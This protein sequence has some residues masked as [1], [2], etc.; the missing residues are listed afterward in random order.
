[1]GTLTRRKGYPV[2]LRALAMLGD[3]DWRLTVV[4]SA[5]WDPGHAREIEELIGKAGLSSRVTVIG[6]QDE[7][8]LAAFYDQ[9]DLF[10]L[11]SHHEG[12]GMVLAEALARGLPIV[13]TTA[14]A[15]PDTV[16]AAAGRLVPPGDA[17]ALAAALRAVLT[18]QDLYQDLKRGAAG[19]RRCLLD[20]TAATR[21]FALEIEG[22]SQP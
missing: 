10:V 9:A 5:S 17:D 18:D 8:G 14:G 20:W 7:A 1:V 2:L 16:P 11:A 3:L 6:E 15:I 22:V 12:Y 13:S 4:G 19:A 21:L